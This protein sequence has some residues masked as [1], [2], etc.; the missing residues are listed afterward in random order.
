MKGCKGCK[1]WNGTRASRRGD[2]QH[3]IFDILP[4]NFEDRFGNKCAA[5]LDPHDLQ[6]YLSDSG[7]HKA[8]KHPVLGRL[9]HGVSRQRRKEIVFWM[10]DHGDQAIKTKD[11]TYMMTHK[12]FVCERYRK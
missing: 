11:L 9:P 2:C 8:M 5:P 3:I 4:M 6:Y 7:I 1:N 12:D 10:D